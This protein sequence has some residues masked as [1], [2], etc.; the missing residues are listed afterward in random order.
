LK[1]DDGTWRKDSQGNI[2]DK[3]GIVVIGKC[4]MD[5]Q[6]EIPLVFRQNAESEMS[7]LLDEIN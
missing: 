5:E 2:C 6:G 1:A 4:M 7:K 3:V